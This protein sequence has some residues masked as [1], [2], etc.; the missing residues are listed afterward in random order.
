MPRIR[1]TFSPAKAVDAV[2]WMLRD[3]L[4][5]G[6]DKLGFHEVLKACYFADKVSLA[7]RRR[8]IFGAEYIAMPYGPVPIEIYEMLKCEPKWLMEM[9]ERENDDY[10]WI[11]E[12]HYIMLSDAE[13]KRRR[14]DEEYN[15]IALVELDIVEEAFKKS[16]SLTF[17]QRTEQTHQEDWLK[18]TKR[19]RNVMW[20]EDMIPEDVPERDEL[21]QTLREN[22]LDYA[23]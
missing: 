4:R 1:F 7:K 19:S 18:G 8:P 9:D 23:L 21:I 10:P 11:R 17:T 13:K 3:A 14:N 2:L 5:N 20:Y 16:S 12:R 15:S 6:K 22:G